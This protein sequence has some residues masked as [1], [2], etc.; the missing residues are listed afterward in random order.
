[1]SRP[2]GRSGDEL[3]P[4]T[5]HRDYTEMAAGSVLVSFGRTVV[6]CTASIDEDVPR[7]M[8]GKGK[9]WV[10]AEYSM[11]PGSSPERV[12]RE[13]A[14]GKQS[15]RTQEIQRLIGRSLRAVCDMRLLGERQVVVDCDVL[16]ADGGTRT[17]SI[18][19]GYLALHDALTR[20]VQNKAIS[21]HPLTSHCAAISVGIVDGVPVLDLPYVEDSRAEVDMNVVMTAEGRFIEVQ[22]TAEGAAFHRS[23]LNSLLDLAELG[24]AEI[25][26]LQSELL[27]EQPSRRA[28]GR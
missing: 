15:G 3:R 13:A 23:E 11:L 10:T 19:G 21:T 5:F 20:L 6:L 26:A 8:K 9:G 28:L 4:I 17:A 2:D 7:W 18:C 12:G 22:G 24:C 1:M 27:A 25:F 14:K 16:Q